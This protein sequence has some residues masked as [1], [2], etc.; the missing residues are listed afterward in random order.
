MGYNKHLDA[1][2][3]FYSQAE[4]GNG[5]T[6]GLESALAKAT[7]A[8]TRLDRELI[9]ALLAGEMRLTILTG[10]AGDG[11]TAFIQTVEQRA[12]EA[13]ASLKRIG[14]VGC[15]FTLNG[16]E[17]RTLYD[18]SVDTE[19]HA[20][21]AMLA[22]FFASL[23]GDEAPGPG[24]CLLVAMNEGKLRDFLAMS[25]AHRWLARQLLDHLN[26]DQPLPEGY[27]VVNLNLRSVV[28]ADPAGGDWMFDQVLDRYV[29][30]KL[31]QD[32]ESCEAKFRCPVKFNVDSFRRFPLDGLSE[33]DREATKA[34]NAAAEAAR[35]RLK[36]LF[37]V[38][39]F[40]KRLH[41]TVRDMRSALAFALF[42]KRTC[43]Q[44]QDALKTGNDDFLPRYYYNALFDPNEKDRVLCFLREFDPGRSA[45]PQLDARISFTPPETPEFRRL[46]N[47]LSNTRVA[48]LGRSR[49][50]EENDL[51]RHFDARTRSPEERDSSVLEAARSYVSAVR[52]K[53]F[54]EG[55]KAHELGD[56]ALQESQHG[57]NELL[58]Y[59]SLSRFTEFVRTGKDEGDKLRNQLVEGI[60]RSE[61]IHDQERSREYVCIRTR[62]DPNAKVKAFFT[63]P[64]SE[65]SCERPDPGPQ[66]R[67]IEYLPSSVLFRHDPTNVVLEVS[68]D[69][70]EMLMRIRDGYVPTAGEMRAFF[71][72]LLMFKK[73]LMAT[74]AGELLL[75]ESDYQIYRVKRTPQQGIAV[76]TL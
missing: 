3:Q 39:H 20:N 29:S 35:A 70:Y 59:E 67:F 51:N 62:Q 48:H 46:F 40:R 18:G 30:D 22:D 54:F 1:F 60:S 65:F 50:D 12:E 38:L 72:N 74:P 37:Q 17:Y 68:L 6:R 57:W 45:A 28:D 56:A 26:E 32:C 14:G 7:Y 64:A 73:Q 31:W 15:D 2:L 66:A 13:G 19:Q 53:L 69:L 33:K 34:R 5:L 16:R 58:P 10:N 21:A 55:S 8:S 11:K 25:S 44:I 36:S 41:I 47:D 43:Q 49:T 9:P 71:L 27:L 63:Y 76:T 4:A 75:T 52:R 42:G 23:A 24:P 61:G